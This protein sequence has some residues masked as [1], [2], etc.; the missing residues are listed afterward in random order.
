MKKVVIFEP[1][2]KNLEHLI[3]NSCMM[4]ILFSIYKNANIVFY[5]DKDHAELIA[6]TNKI[7]LN[8]IYLNIPEGYG[9]LFIL[10]KIIF[11]FVCTLKLA[12]ERPDI[13]VYLS[14]TPFTIL[15]SKIFLKKVTI[16]YILHG[17]LEILRLRQQ[18]MNYY[19]WLWPALRIKRNNAAHIV[20]G[21]SIKTEAERILP[22][23]QFEVIDHPYYSL[24][25]NHLLNK[26]P[27]VINIGAV[28]FGHIEKGSHLI[29]D[30]GKMIGKSDVIQLHYI[31]Q[32][33][34][35]RILMPDNTE[36]RIHGGDKPLPP[37]EFAKWIEQMHYCLFFYPNY[38]YRLTAS[39]AIFDALIHLKPVIAIRNLYFEYVF[40]KMG[41]IGYLCED[42]EE[43]SLII[44]TLSRP[45][46]K[47]IYFEQQKN[48][49]NGLNSFSVESVQKQM[50]QII[51]KIENRNS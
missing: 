11:D 17:I 25:N 16:F 47:D 43:M 44:N 10:K 34:D 3:F 40:N 2:C 24:V 14:V 46:M 35:K 19:Y 39:G 29:F 4:K 42:I 12:K 8:K 37:D 49:R 41:N 18:P 23:V 1:Q 31:G 48:I 7:E 26:I 5:G 13:L 36:V 33:L 38:S 30:L 45:D 6:E 51:L 21:E 28:G 50:E 32:F 9:R 27:S 20:L 15:F 22:D